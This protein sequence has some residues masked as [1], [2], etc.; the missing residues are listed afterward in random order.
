VPDIDMA[1]L[2]ARMAELPRDSIGRPV[3][4]FVWFDDD[5]K[6]DFRVVGPGKLQQALRGSLCWVCGHGFG[7]GEDRAWL[8]GP[9]C[10]V[11]LVTAEPPSHLDCA[12]WSARWCPFL[13][14]PN[15]VRRD[16]HLPKEAVNPAGIM[17]RRNP[18][19]S[20]VWVTGY[21]S[22]KTEKEDGGFLFRL[23]PA[24]R[25]LWFAEGREATRAEVLASIDSGLPLLREAAEQDGPDAL[26]DLGR[27]HA[28]ALA[29]V[30]AEAVT[31]G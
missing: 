3:P 24:K 19:T 26:A 10:T 8:I 1:T 7:G 20:V 2:P 9:M 13:S 5:G 28:A 12:V 21:R 18:G 29:Y 15:M 11:N 22:W 30:P 14:T 27:M 4:W 31:H 23:G 6:P 25:A 17:I 16:R